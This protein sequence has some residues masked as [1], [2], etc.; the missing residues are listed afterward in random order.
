VASVTHGPG[1]LNCMTALVEASK[2]RCPL[3]LLTAETSAGRR[4][5]LQSIDLAGVIAPT[6]AAFV[7]TRRPQD[8]T[9]ELSRALSRAVTEQRP[10]ELDV[11]VDF[12]HQEV[13]YTKSRRAPFAPRR[14]Q[15]APDD[16]N[17]ASARWPG[18]SARSCSRALA[19]STRGP[20]L[21]SL[22]CRNYSARRS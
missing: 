18:A 1:T 19:S 3:V 22:C 5:H 11:P 21:S 13:D 14:Q 4:N 6:G 20:R 12:L 15:P 17:M 16:I 9:D 2:A 10:V 8:V 7:H